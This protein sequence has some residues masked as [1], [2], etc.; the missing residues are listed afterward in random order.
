MGLKAVLKQ[1]LIDD[2]GVSTGTTESSGKEA[3]TEEAPVKKTVALQVKSRTKRMFLKQREMTPR[4]LLRK[5]VKSRTKR[6]AA[7]KG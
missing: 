6:M 5:R 4:R 3:S 7:K 1:R 2:I